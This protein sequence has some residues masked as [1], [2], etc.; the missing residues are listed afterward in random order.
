MLLCCAWFWFLYD[1][2]Q[3]LTTLK[4]HDD[5][6]KWKHCP[7]YWPFVRGIHRA[8]VNS[9]H[10]GQWRR[11]LIFSF[12]CAWINGCVNNHKAGDLRRHHVHYDIAIFMMID[13]T[14]HFHGIT[15]IVP[16][17]VC[18]MFMLPGKKVIINKYAL[19]ILIEILL[20]VCSTVSTVASPP[21]AA[22]F[23]VGGKGELS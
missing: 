19:A 13:M 7:R 6:I 5:V 20:S 8:T 4:L 3:V 18:E 12:I 14:Y 22:H 21:H 15:Y 17:T 11:A 2:P 16:A 10:K 23:R 1:K 9:A